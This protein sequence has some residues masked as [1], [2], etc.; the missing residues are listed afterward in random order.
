MK[1]S[2]EYNNW[3]GTNTG[4]VYHRLD[5]ME[6]RISD[7]EVKAVELIQREQQKEEEF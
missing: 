6:K 1:E 3:T 4:G 5:D 2:Y 7:L